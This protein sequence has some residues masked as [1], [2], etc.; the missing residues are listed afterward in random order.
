ME[1]IIQTF[2][3][4]KTE[5]INS[6][7]SEKSVEKNYDVIYSLVEIEK[8]NFD[9]NYLLAQAYHLI[10][11]NIYASKIID[12][13][14]IDA[15]KEVEI[16]KLKKLQQKVDNQ[17]TWR[18]THYRD[19][20]DAKII[21]DPTILCVNDFIITKDQNEFC[22]EIIDRINNIIILNKNVKNKDIW[23]KKNNYI[24]FST[25]EP[26]KSLLLKLADYIKWLGE[27]KVELLDFYNDFSFI[28]GKLDHVEQKWYDGLKVFD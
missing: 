1:N 3:N 11:Q 6:N 16:E 19:L 14:L 8:R 13:N 28:E 4:A 5:F 20:R 2:I 24:I 12:E 10:G 15:T 9:E 7:A 18:I 23:G 27:L 22:I 21:K 25:I 26:N 17:D